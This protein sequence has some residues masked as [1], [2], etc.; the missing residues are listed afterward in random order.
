M[1]QLFIFK[2]TH[3]CCILPFTCFILLFTTISCK[4][5]KRVA[6]F[7]DLPDEVS[8]SPFY[9]H[10]APYKDL[11]I[12]QA[13]IL[14]INIQTVDSPANNFS[15]NSLFPTL[16]SNAGLLPPNTAIPTFTVD[17]TGFVEI[18]VL[19][20]V[21]VIGLTTQMIRDSIH[22]LACKF[23]KNPIVNVRLSNFG[24][25]VL[26]EVG[27]PGSY[28]LPNEKV[29][30]LDALGIAGDITIYGKKDNVLLLRQQD[31]KK[32]AVRFD[33]NSSL[34]LRSPYFFLQQGDVIYVEPN[35]AKITASTEGSKTRNYAL[36]ASGL[37]VLIILISR[38]TF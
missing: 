8:T 17:Q 2:R 21:S 37:S 23:Y 13:D 35:K 29:S 32:D 36:I 16:I 38:L 22:L 5:T 1:D 12:R 10:L 30:L 34:S 28:I 19:G 26:G 20:K 25:S 11:V 27:K 31:R 4:T 9:L 14:Q 24:I 3:V 33:L 18:P 6:Y 15:D 7:Q